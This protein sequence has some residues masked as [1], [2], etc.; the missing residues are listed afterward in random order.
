MR[1][2]RFCAHILVDA[3]LERRGSAH[4]SAVRASL[5][6]ANTPAHVDHLVAAVRELANR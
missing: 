5:G 3:L 2:G 1:D 6:L 4:T